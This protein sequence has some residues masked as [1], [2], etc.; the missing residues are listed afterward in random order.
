[1]GSRKLDRMGLDKFVV[2]RLSFRGITTAKDLLETSP[3]AIAIFLDISLIEAK[4]IISKVCAKIANK[5]QTALELL[6]A[7][8]LRCNN[9]PTGIK[10]LD[11]IM[12]GGLNVG[13]ISEI[14]GP[15]GAYCNDAKCRC[16]NCHFHSFHFC[17]QLEDFHWLHQLLCALNRPQV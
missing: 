1:M 13:S 9:L 10:D 17:L 3:F 4:T 14:C 11:S 2:E 8:E 7:R 15:P 16:R 12:K 6:K 5:N